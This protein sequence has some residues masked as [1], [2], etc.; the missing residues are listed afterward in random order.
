[1]SEPETDYEK[2]RFDPNLRKRKETEIPI[3]DVPDFGDVELLEKMFKELGRRAKTPLNLALDNSSVSPSSGQYV[4]SLGN[5]SVIAG[6]LDRN[7]RF[8]RT[9][10][11]FMPIGSDS[12]CMLVGGRDFHFIMGDFGGRDLHHPK[13]PIESVIALGREVY[14][15]SRTRQFNIDSD[16]R[17]LLAGEREKVN[18]AHRLLTCPDKEKLLVYLASRMQIRPS[19]AILLY[20]F[21]TMGYED[22]YRNVVQKVN[23]RLRE[24]HK[25]A[26]STTNFDTIE[27]PET[28]EKISLNNPISLNTR[29]I[30]PVIVSPNEEG[31]YLVAAYVSYKTKNQ[32]G[33]NRKRRRML[34]GGVV[35]QQKI[36]SLITPVKYKYVAGMTLNARDFPLQPKQ[37]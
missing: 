27:V 4:Y 12:L 34:L 26:G 1:M 6:I 16:S 18:L 31:R 24:E 32:D 30:K 11:G 37:R 25:R 8:K 29:R 7:E 10:G 13:D 3:D 22:Q 28:I 14:G 21:H 35:E 9:Q 33:S 17:V 2:T 19:D 36:E 5:D 15:P 20:K 23:D